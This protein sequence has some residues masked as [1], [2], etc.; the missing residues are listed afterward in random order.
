MTPQEK[1][2]ELLGKYQDVQYEKSVEYEDETC[3]FEYGLPLNIAKQCAL[4]AVEIEMNSLKYIIQSDS[5]GTAGR[6]LV[7]GM[8]REL[9]EVKQEI[10]K[11][12]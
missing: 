4:I 3:V 1:A 2:K 10:E 9:N 12:I 5:I 6:V 7:A 8:V 11:L